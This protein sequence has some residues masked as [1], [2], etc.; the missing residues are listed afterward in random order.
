M[1]RLCDFCDVFDT[2]RENDRRNLPKGLR[3]EYKSKLCIETY[4]GRLH[5]GTTSFKA[6]KLNYC[7]ECGRRLEP[8]PKS[9]SR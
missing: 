3:T 5:R 9:Q 4:K 6:M 1:E 8:E 7:P 2:L